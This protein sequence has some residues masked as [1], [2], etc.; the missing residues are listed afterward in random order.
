MEWFEEL[1]KDCPPA[2]A[3]I[4]NAFVCFR[5]SNDS[6]KPHDIDFLS[7]RLRYPNKTFRNVSECVAHSLSVFD[8]IEKCRDIAKLPRNR[9]KFQRI[10][11]IEL[12]K[13]DGLIK[14]TFRESHY[15]WWRSKSFKVESVI[16]I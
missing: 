4:P 5:W 8:D 9:G 7:E 14:K 1:P 11:K 16:L 10:M 6:R 13:E 2:N 15:S 3:Q 12:A